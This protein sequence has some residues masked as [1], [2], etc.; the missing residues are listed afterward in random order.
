MNLEFIL[1]LT[2]FLAVSAWLAYFSRASLRFPRSHGFYR[3][4]AWVCILALFLLNV[5]KW[6]HNPFSLSQLISWLL[7]IIS[8]FLVLHAV[9][10]LRR[11][12]QQDKKREDVQLIG[13]EKTTTL[14]TTGAYRYIRHPMYSSLLFLGWGLFF[15][16]PSWAAGMI[17]IVA[18]CFIV[19]TAKADEV[20]S[21]RF[22]GTPYEEY[23]K[24][25]KM[26]IPFLF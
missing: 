17:A 24:Q 19:G 26:F 11:F 1:K 2:L 4:F 25:T 15:K 8:G 9:Y 5:G 21:I 16:S 6:F 13:I 20:E 23:M 3:Y 7:L 22:F 14:V 10:L 12:G 18:T